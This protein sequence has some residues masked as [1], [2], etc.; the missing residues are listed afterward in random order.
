MNGPHKVAGA[1]SGANLKSRSRFQPLV[2]GN[3]VS[4]IFELQE[5][6]SLGTG[7]SQGERGGGR[8]DDF[9]R[10]DSRAAVLGPVA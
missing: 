2:A 6:F 3:P 10:P 8:A 5:K 4:N 1:D 7:F 9:A